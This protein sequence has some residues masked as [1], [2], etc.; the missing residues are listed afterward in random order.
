M[1]FRIGWFLCS[2]VVVFHEAGRLL[3]EDVSTPPAGV[4]S[5]NPKPTS[6]SVLFGTA[7]E[8]T[9]SMKEMLGDCFPWS[10]PSV[11]F[12]AQKGQYI[13]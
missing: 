1:P 12:D 8:N 3:A 4:R 10:I 9:G 6:L 11:K 13:R 5:D 7:M 2:A